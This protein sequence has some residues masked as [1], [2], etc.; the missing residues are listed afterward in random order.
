MFVDSWRI[1]AASSA[2]VGSAMEVT[3]GDE[4]AT[5]ACDRDGG[6]GLGGAMGGAAVEDDERLDRDTRLSRALIPK[7]AGPRLRS[8]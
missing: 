7:T 3:E 6:V 5:A 2:M 8:S 1:M 4:V